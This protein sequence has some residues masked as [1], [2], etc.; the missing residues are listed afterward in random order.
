MAKNVRAGWCPSL[1]APPTETL[2]V[3]VFSHLVHF[4]PWTF[5]SGPNRVSLPIY[6]YWFQ[7]SYSC[8]SFFVC[9]CFSDC[10][11]N[12]SISLVQMPE[13]WSS[14]NSSNHALKLS[15]GYQFISPW[16]KHIHKLKA[17]IFWYSLAPTLVGTY[18][19][20][21]T[22]QI[23]KSSQIIFRFKTHIVR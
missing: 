7:P 1:I 19:L 12:L 11:W 23:F 14:M 10:Q 21:Y 16:I 20:L 4:V 6:L 9:F 13:L 15:S 17:D 22:P 8:P 2:Q 5:R 3:C 18:F